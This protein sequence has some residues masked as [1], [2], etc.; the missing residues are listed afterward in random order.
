MNFR[1]NMGLCVQVDRVDICLAFSKD[2]FV[3]LKGILT[4]IINRG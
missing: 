2:S 1:N 4:H 3:K